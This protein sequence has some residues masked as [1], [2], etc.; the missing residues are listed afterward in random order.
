MIVVDSSVAVKWLLEEEGSDRAVEL[1]EEQ[2]LAA[3]SLLRAEVGN[4]LL[5]KVRR[6]DIAASAAI[7]AHASLG[8]FIGQWEVMAT[9]ADDAFAITLELA[10]PVYD[11]YY[12]ALAQVRGVKLVTAD[13][14][15]LEVCA[16]TR[17][18]SSV[19][20]L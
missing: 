5:K 9:L 18:E 8:N 10:H 15:L 11:C 14:R 12:I 1:A 4:A 17:F 3:P 7:V 19:T 20:G 16:G 6:G 2:A 13:Q